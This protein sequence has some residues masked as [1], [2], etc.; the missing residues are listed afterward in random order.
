[1]TRW[2]NLSGWGKWSALSVMLTVVLVAL[3][4]GP[5]PSRSF[6]EGG[7]WQNI[8][9]IYSTDIKGKIEPCG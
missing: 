4:Q 8:T 5:V 2:K 9:L 1:M 6:A 3:S 7:D